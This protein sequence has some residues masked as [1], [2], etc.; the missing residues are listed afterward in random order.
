MGP[1]AS[2]GN[3]RYMESRDY[4]DVV[5]PFADAVGCTWDPASPLNNL[6]VFADCPAQRI[7]HF[8]FRRGGRVAARSTEK[9]FTDSPVPVAQRDGTKHVPLSDHYGL[10][11]TLV[12]AAPLEG[13]I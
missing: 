5:A 4:E 7:D 1:E 6:P 12:A 8:F 10:M 9:L 2:A 11:V 13:R 3:Y